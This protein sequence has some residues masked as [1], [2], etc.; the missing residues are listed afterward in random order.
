MVE[1]CIA[2]NSR[3]ANPNRTF[4]HGD[5]CNMDKLPDA[6][7][8]ICKDVLQHWCHADIR[9]GLT[10][11]LKYRWVL[12]TNS[13]VCGNRRLNAEISTGDVRALDLLQEPYSLQATESK[14]YEVITNCEPDLK[15]IFLWEPQPSAHCLKLPL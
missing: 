8:A 1:A 3:Y 15:L 12:I 2:D 5:W 10:R 4:L 11:L 9:K 6:D 13:I 14:I 7:F